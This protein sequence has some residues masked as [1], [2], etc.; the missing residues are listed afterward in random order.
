VKFFLSFK[1]KLLI[2]VFLFISLSVVFGSPLSASAEQ[3]EKTYIL[4]AGKWGKQQN[5]AAIMAG[6]TVTFS[7]GET[8]VGIVVSSVPDFLEK[9]L[10]SHA[11]T[12]GAEDMLI[13]WQPPTEVVKFD[14]AAVT[15]GD[16]TFFSLQWHLDAIEAPAAWN[17]GFTGKGVRIAV[18][19]GG[20]PAGHIDIAPNLDFAASA[21]FVPGFNFDEDTGVFRHAGHVAG[22]AA[23]PDNGMGTIGVAPEATII[24]VKVLHDG[25]GYFSWIM[26][27]IEYASRSLAEGGAGADIINMSLRGIFCKN[28]GG[29]PLVAALNKIINTA[30]K[31][32]VLVISAAGNDGFNF[33]QSWDCI[34]IPAESGNGIA[35]SATGPV[36]WA[37]GSTNF[38]RPASYTNY[39]NSLVHVAAPGG[40]NVLPGDDVC[41]VGIVTHYCWVFD[42]VFSVYGGTNLYGWVDGTSMAT[43]VVAGV[44]ALIKQRFPNI[45]VGAWKNMLAN[46]A[47]DEGK[48][49]HDPFYGR[50]F[51]NAL[52]AVIE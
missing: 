1:I 10:A 9:A 20:M 39:G 32:G 26:Q 46:S 6:G 31:R 40:D 14:D 23:A 52:R 15:P 18:L 4:T 50:G 28:H 3:A 17:A 12:D 42:M 41:T 21:S 2:A 37:L 11:F 38:R 51:V 30:T 24:G 36:G 48:P 43:P 45:S 34:V 29:G 49:G 19:D 7:H 25:G 35:I 33:D 44:A 5:T 47:D 13:Q 22:I 27:G 16:E 8:G